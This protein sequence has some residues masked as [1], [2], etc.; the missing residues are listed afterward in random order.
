MNLLDKYITT[1]FIFK[2]CFI[3]LVIVDLYYKMKG[4]V[5]SIAYKKVTYWKDRIEFIFVVLMSSLLIYVFNPRHSKINLIDTEMTVLFYLF[6]F[7]LLVSSKWH[8]FIT[9]SKWYKN[10]LKK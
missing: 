1:I 6:G 3:I 2:I 9:E 4:D 10:Y 7:V 5:Q 8:N